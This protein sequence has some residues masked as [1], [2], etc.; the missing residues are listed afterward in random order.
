MYRLQ[1]ES[2][3]LACTAVQNHLNT[4]YSIKP[5]EVQ[6]LKIYAVISKIAKILREIIQLRHTRH[7]VLEP[8][9][10]GPIHHPRLHPKTEPAGTADRTLATRQGQGAGPR[11]STAATTAKTGRLYNNQKEDQAL[12]QYLPSLPREPP[13]WARQTCSSTQRD[14]N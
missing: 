2:A 5:T 1:E 14:P 4:A 12:P 6:D 9:T 3:R 10:T 8:T 11:R 7:S 13:S